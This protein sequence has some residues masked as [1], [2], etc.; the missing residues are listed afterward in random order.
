MHSIVELKYWIL[1]RRRCRCLTFGKINPSEQTC[2]SAINLLTRPNSSR[3]MNG[4]SVNNIRCSQKMRIFNPNRPMG[5]LK[6]HVICDEEIKGSTWQFQA[7]HNPGVVPFTTMLDLLNSVLTCVM[8]IANFILQRTFAL[9][10]SW[11]RL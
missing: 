5:D 4:L 6:S 8:E 3:P 2:K 11:H 9:G 1:I 7:L 10:P